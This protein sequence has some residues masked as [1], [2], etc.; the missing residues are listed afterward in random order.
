MCVYMCVCIYQA[1][2]FFKKKKKKEKNNLLSIFKGSFK[3]P[4][5]V[6]IFLQKIFKLGM[7]MRKFQAK[8]TYVIYRP[9]LFGI[10]KEYILHICGIGKCHPLP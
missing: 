4:L 8:M 7:L 5:K 6:F 2:F 3:A 9:Y 1:T 10:S